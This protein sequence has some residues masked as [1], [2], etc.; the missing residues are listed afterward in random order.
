MADLEITAQEVHE[1]LARGEDLLL[2]DCREPEELRIARLPRAQHIPLREIPTQSADLDT[3][4]E[5]IVL[6]HHGVRSARA[7]AFLREQ[8]GF[9]RVRS[10]RGGID[11]WSREIDPTIPRY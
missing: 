3:E 2:V 1:R 7:A 11:A 9:R 5:P 4:R 6:C 8:A 10:L